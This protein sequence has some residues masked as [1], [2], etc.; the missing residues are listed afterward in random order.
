MAPKNG[1]IKCRT[2]T[3]LPNDEKWNAQQV[4]R[5]K[6]VPW[7]PVPGRTDRRVPVAIDRRGNGIQPEDGD[8]EIQEQDKIADEEEQ[9]M[10][11]RGGPDKFHVSK[12]AIERYGPTEGCP[13]CNIIK[14][15]GGGIGRVGIHHNDTCR[16]KV[17][18]T[19]K[20]DPQYR[21]LMQKHHGML[22]IIH[23]N[24][25]NNNHDTMREICRRLEEQKSHVRKAMHS[26]KQKMNTMEQGIKAQL[27]QTMLQMLIA[28]MDVAEF[29]SPPRIA[30]MATAMGLRGG[31]EHGHH[32]E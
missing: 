14:T 24:Q 29:Y 21:Q 26:A 23:N 4:L 30:K 22:D 27:D 15:R 17:T 18:T 2:I 6:G 11:F 3:R 20:Q 10:Q 13:A 16:N 1:I 12:R 25:N 28:S 31:L 9:E 32:D 8:D 5:V 19:M 7:E